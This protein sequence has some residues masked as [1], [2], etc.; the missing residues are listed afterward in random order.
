MRE[1]REQRGVPKE[2]LD[3]C[4]ET[5]RKQ[6]QEAKQTKPKKKKNDLEEWLDDVLTE[7]ISNFCTGAIF[8]GSIV[9]GMFVGPILMLPPGEGFW[10]LLLSIF[11]AGPLMCWMLSWFSFLLIC[12]LIIWPIKTLVLFFR[13]STVKHLEK[14]KNTASLWNRMEEGVGCIL[15]RKE[16]LVLLIILVAIV[17]AILLY[18]FP[19]PRYTSKVMHTGHGIV[20]Q[21]DRW[22]GK[23]YIIYLDG[24]RRQVQD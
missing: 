17:L 4:N 5:R 15:A 8:V 7:P 23:S 16:R 19:I 22:T 13:D 21:H 3:W 20:Y 6:A 11:I 10:M 2:F 24:S 18:L 9:V 14:R 12:L 1:S